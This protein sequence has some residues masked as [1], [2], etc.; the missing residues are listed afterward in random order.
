[1]GD[2]PETTCEEHKFKTRHEEQKPKGEC[3]HYWIIETAKGPT[4]EGV[5]KYCGVEKE[6][7][8]SLPDSQW[9]G[10]ISTLSEL[11]ALPHVEPDRE[12]D[13]D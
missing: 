2:K 3:R 13:N 5:C 11:H 8:N 6:F 12:E 1:M 9:G 10:G 4:S 7:L